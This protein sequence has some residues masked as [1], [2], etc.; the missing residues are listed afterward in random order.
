MLTNGDS[1]SAFQTAAGIAP[2]KIS[3]L[4]RTGLLVLVFLW[5]A[6]CIYGEIHQFKQ[7]EIEIYAVMRKLFRILTLVV[8]MMALVFIA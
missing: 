5:A 6:W 3:L 7:H 1:L 8:L 2:E 4:L